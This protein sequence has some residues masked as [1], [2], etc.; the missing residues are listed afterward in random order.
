MGVNRLGIHYIGYGDHRFDI[1]GVDDKNN[2]VLKETI[3]LVNNKLDEALVANH[4]Q[5]ILN[6][7]AFKVKEVS[8]TLSIDGVFTHTLMLPKMNKRD[9]DN[10]FNYELYI[11]YPDFYNVYSYNIIKHSDE[12][13]VFNYI[14]F[15][16]FKLLEPLFQIAKT[17]SLKVKNITYSGYSL[18]RLNEK[19]AGWK[20][21]SAA[22]VMNINDYF[23]LLGVVINGDCIDYKYIDFGVKKLRV[24]LYEQ[25]GISDETF[26]INLNDEEKRELKTKISKLIEPIYLALTT[27][28]AKYQYSFEKKVLSELIIN[29][30]DDI[31]Q[32]ISSLIQENIGIPCRHESPLDPKLNNFLIPYAALLELRKNVTSFTLTKQKVRIKKDLIEDKN[33]PKKKKSSF[34]TFRLR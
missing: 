2:I 6:K 5:L 20:Q 22:I 9:Y 26:I 18:F 1:I 11:S 32:L 14:V 33:P 10:S 19:V 27:I 24:E 28:G 12:V 7:Y 34:W 30:D 13:S 29:C 23:T 17:L 8:F 15:C 4:I 21:D 3:S 25:Y 16:P 31:V